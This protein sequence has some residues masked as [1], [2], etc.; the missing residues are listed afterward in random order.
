MND[1]H[2]LMR[3]LTHIVLVVLAAAGP[4]VAYAQENAVV[5][6]VAQGVVVDVQDADLRTVIA[7]LA[8]AGGLNVVYNDLPPKLVTL[9][10]NDPVPRSEIR[11]LLKSLVESA[12]FQLHDEGSMLRISAP[13]V[14]PGLIPAPQAGASQVQLFVYRLKHAPAARLAATLQSLFGL[15]NTP[16]AGAAAT[17]RPSSLSEELRQQLV[18]PGIPTAPGASAP[19]TVIIGARVQGEVQ[20]VPDEITNSLLI[21]ASQADWSVISSAIE[22]LDLRPLQVLVEVL[23]AE[24]RRSSLFDLGLS[25]ST[26]LKH[27]PRT[28]ADIG[29]ELAGS[30]TGDVVL[31]ILNLGRVDA[32]ILISSMYSRSDIT[33]LSRPVIFAQNNQDARIMIGSERPFVQVFRA[34]PTDAAVRDQVVQYRDVGTSL[35]IRP[36]INYDGYV[37]MDLVQEVSTATSEVQFGAPVISTREAS[38]RLLVKN[39][40]TA[41]I[42]GLIDRQHDHTRSGIPILRDIPLLGWLFGSTHDNKIETELFLFITPH[43]VVDDQDL[44]RVREQIEG[45]NNLLKKQLP[46]NRT[47]V[48]PDTTASPR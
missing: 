10:L 28:G 33:I 18:P 34:L 48:Q 2:G 5:K 12:G 16:D 25:A 41:V 46:R 11:P 40:Q 30:T 29:G 8:A 36:T 7:A 35:K 6:T 17:P 3:N 20:I 27:E 4:G 19:A 14:Q 39:G 22:A 38:T 15:A 1:W 42:G 32:D 9:R 45:N 21:R 26:P 13:Q 47:I 44:D 23:I 31:K 24:V 37:S 43:I